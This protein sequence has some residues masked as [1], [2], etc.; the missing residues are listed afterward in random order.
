MIVKIS[1]IYINK[2]EVHDGDT[3]IIN[4]NGTIE[5]SE[6]KNNGK[7]DN[8]IFMVHYK[9][10]ERKLRFNKTSLVGCSNVWGVDTNALVGKEVIMFVLPTPNGEDKMIVIKPLIKQNNNE[11]AWDDK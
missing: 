6:S 9:N 1:G 3:A 8:T 11:A 7:K 2:K 10:E 4:D 5:V